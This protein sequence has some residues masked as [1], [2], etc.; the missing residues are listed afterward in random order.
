MAAA[1][2]LRS[3][4]HV[5][6]LTKSSR[7]VSLFF[8]DI[9]LN[10]T[11]S[12]DTLP[13]STFHH[14]AKK[15]NYYDLVTTL[16][17]ELLASL[18]PHIEAVS[19]D[20]EP[21]QRRIHHNTAI[22]FLYLFL[23]LGSPRSLSCIYSLRSTIPLGA[24]LG[25]SASV[26]VCLASALLLQAHALSGPH[27][28]QPSAES[29]LQLERINRWAFV[30]ECCIHGNPSGIDNTVST[31]GK[32]VVFQ[33]KDYTQPPIVKPL[34]RF[35]TLPL[36]LINTRQPRST[37]TEVAKV[38]QLRQA[39]PDIVNGILN[40]I[41]KVTQSAYNMIYTAEAAGRDVVGDD[42]LRHLGE[43]MNLNHGLLVALG[44]SHFKLERLRALVDQAG[45]GW[46]KL[47]GA[48][49][50]GC[51][52]TLLNAK[53]CA[54]SVT[55]ADVPLMEKG[56]QD[57]QDGGPW[58]GLQQLERDLELEGFE[59]YDTTLGGDGVGVLL[60]A[61]LHNG[62]VESE[63]GGEE[64]DQ[65]KFLRVEGREGVEKLVG[66]LGPGRGVREGWR[67]WTV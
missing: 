46:T 50:G 41:D 14:P 28:D 26:T 49:G 47:T 3:Y 22:A 66:V 13:W 45:V 1:I 32:A 64:I 4:L 54:T 2:S 63:E 11:W 15:R 10:H 25:S 57:G 8:P 20:A 62:S 56:S 21:H 29:A 5:H 16:D 52:I 23:S 40:E 59:K 30:G 9:S 24:G 27:P 6:T 34:L 55:K 44:V 67:F 65:E 42:A 37:A 39:H 61:V 48:G 31:Q 33:R 36:L 51:A 18:K 17:Q 53:V 35:P 43:L 58:G 19:P 12:I 60:P 38:A 7:T